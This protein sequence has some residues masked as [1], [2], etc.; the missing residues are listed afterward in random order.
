M[1]RCRLVQMFIGMALFLLFAGN[2]RAQLLA[3]ESSTG[4]AAESPFKALSIITGLTVTN[5]SN[6]FRQPTAQEDTIT[7]G[8]LGLRLDKS[9]SQQQFQLSVIQRATRYAKFSYLNFDA[10]DYDGGWNW[11]LGKRFSGR[12]SASRTQSLAPFNDA[13]GTGRNVRI[14]QTQALDIDAWVDGGWHALFGLS[15]TDQK[16]EQ[17]TLSRTPDFKAVNASV[18]VKYLTRAGNSMTVRQQTTAGEYTSNAVGAAPM[19]DYTEDLTEISADW[20]PNGASALNGRVGW[21]QRTNKDPARRNFSGPSSSVSYTW[22]PGGKLSALVTAAQ[23]TVPLQD[24]SASYRE[25]NSLS[26]SPAWQI[27]DK[28]SSYLR[29]SYTKSNDKGAINPPPAG[30]RRDTFS[31]AAVGL[32]WAATRKL[33]INA[34]VEYQQRSSNIA[35]TEYNATIAR[36]GASLAF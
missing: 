12:L 28:T 7:S 2:I 36:I 14:S 4:T 1:L 26:F 25:E 31:A 3:P 30:P 22:T 27:S 19:S 32:D 20:K 16:S 18:G 35:L 21:L 11:Q 24:L 13:L 23:K 8:Y 10:T 15:Q 5:D 34:S 9:Y 33:K 17:N 6:I 29:V